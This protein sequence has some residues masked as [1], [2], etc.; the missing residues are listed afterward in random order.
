MSR[1]ARVQYEEAVLARERLQ[2]TVH[3]RKAEALAGTKKAK[4]EQ[5]R[6][7]IQKVGQQALAALP[8]ECY[9]TRECPAAGNPHPAC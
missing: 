2:S 7:L 1:G 6:Q 5:Q 4:H 8:R 3:S 9:A